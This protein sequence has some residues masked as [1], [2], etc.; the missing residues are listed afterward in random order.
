[1]S[2]IVELVVESL[3]PKGAQVSNAPPTRPISVR[4]SDDLIA[5]IDVL[6]HQ[7]G[8]T[9]SALI[10]ESLDEMAE[11]GMAALQ[12]HLPSDEWDQIALQ[13]EERM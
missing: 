11:E 13:L 12:E 8:K 10:A 4:L 1:M 6:A 5:R 3:E 7:V 2:N 9:R